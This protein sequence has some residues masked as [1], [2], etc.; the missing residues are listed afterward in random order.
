[1]A[2]DF[3]GYAE[4]ATNAINASN[5]RP[6]AREKLFGTA[7]SNFKE[8]TKRVIN[9][10]TDPLVQAAILDIKDWGNNVDFGN[11]KSAGTA[12]MEWKKRLN[13]PQNMRTNNYARDNNLD[14]FAAFKQMYDT[15]MGFYAP[16]VMNKLQNHQIMNH[17]SDN[18]MQELLYNTP[19]L[20]SLLSKVPPQMDAQGMPMAQPSWVVPRQTWGQ[21]QPF[22]RFKSLGMGGAAAG[23]G[24]VG[25]KAASKYLPESFREGASKVI[26]NPGFKKLGKLS[27]AAAGAEL[28]ATGMETLAKSLGATKKTQALTKEGV[29]ALT[30]GVM[31]AIQ[32][33]GFSKVL[34]EVFKKGGVKLA[35]RTL[36]KLGAGAIGGVAT[37]GIA[38]AAM[39]AWTLKDIMDIV[40]IVNNMK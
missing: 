40:D 28:G 7:E 32:A 35:G 18:D 10:G 21:M 33:H 34:K 29:S 12:Y 13:L 5:S 16:M 3:R 15:Q 4:A 14:N 25:V 11:M 1:M 17:L 36:A 22:D 8:D 38:T 27:L 19:G 37:G 2:L 31:T 30:G 39:A 23:A 20:Q 26:K 9:S 6:S 24:Y